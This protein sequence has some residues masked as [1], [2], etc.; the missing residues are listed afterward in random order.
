MEI[1]VF[2]KGQDDFGKGETRNGEATYTQHSPR[3]EKRD[4]HIYYYPENA[5]V[6]IYQVKEETEYYH[7]DGFTCVEGIMT[8]LLVNQRPSDLTERL[9]ASP[10]QNMVELGAELEDIIYELAKKYNPERVQ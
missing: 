6:G 8:N 5:H 3:S 2:I 1:H 10:M 9:K 7:K 4:I